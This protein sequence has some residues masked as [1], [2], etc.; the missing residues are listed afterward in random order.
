MPIVPV[1]SETQVNPQTGISLQDPF[2]AVL[3]DGGWVA[4]WSAKKD[5]SLNGSSQL[6]TDFGVYAQRFFADGSPRGSEFRV[7]TNLPGNQSVQDILATDDGGF[8]VV[9]ES[10]NQV[11][12]SSKQDVYTQK[13]DAAGTATGGEVLVNTT[14]SRTEYRPHLSSGKDGGWVVTWESND[15]V[16]S[17]AFGDEIYSQAYNASGVRVGGELRVN[18]YT[19]DF[20]YGQQAAALPGGG[21]VVVWTSFGEE[22]PAN[23]PDYRSGVYAQILDGAGNATGLPVHVNTHVLGDQEQPL[24]VVL[25][26]GGWVVAWVSFNFVHTELAQDGD[27]YGVFMQRFAANGSFVGSETQVNTYTA[28]VQNFHTLTALH[29]GG[30]VVTW[31]SY[32]QDTADSYGVYQQAYGSTGQKLGGETQVNSFT[33]DDQEDSRVVA[34][35]SGGWVVVWTSDNQ[36][37]S[38][39]GVYQQAF[40]ADGSKNGSE[41]RVNEATA[42]EQGFYGLTIE[43]LPDDKWVVL[44][45]S[46]TSDFAGDL[47]MQRVFSLNSNAA[48]TD[49]SSPALKVKEGAANSFKIGKF[50]GVDPDSST[51]TWTLLDNAGGRFKIDADDG[52][53]HVANGLLLDYEASK[54]HNINVQVSDGTSTRTETFTVKVDDVANE[55][56]TGGTNAD[57][58]GG[59]SKSDTLKGG[60]GNDTLKG[61]GGKD[62]LDGGK[63]SDTADYSDKTKAIEVTLKASG[64]TVKVDGKAEDIIKNLENVV[65]GSKNDKLTGD[66]KANSLD[67]RTG[68]DVL[69]GEGGNDTL[70]GGGGK[71]T[72]TGGAGKDHFVFTTAPG[73]KNVDTLKDFEHNKDV[74]HWDEVAFAATGPTIEDAEFRTGKAA[75]ELDDRVIYDKS[76]GK[77]YYDADGN[78]AGG[79]DQ[80]LV[81]I[82]ANKPTLDAGDFV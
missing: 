53:L 80:V 69:S 21:Q 31:R 45:S 29:G 56:L 65:G 55:N 33:H 34:L 39:R 22:N 6:V 57:S 58:L 51:L 44:W 26:D 20:Q 74:F 16:S 7:S 37:G 17:T 35:D 18:T 60:N 75:K 25:D 9:W 23:L 42:D 11:G 76:S 13:Y 64:A 46:E 70:I 50:I 4:V 62:S 79:V 36:D 52:E 3:E 77:L 72:L 15:G 63:G 81:A 24:V 68:N 41:T 67:G 66:S 12:P 5:Q 40:N 32:G 27:Q 54:S 73:T 61:G 78:L 82:L 14:T 71:D 59:G 30:W 10:T 8:V 47:L 49:I 19:T 2:L 1:S 38:G 48:P 28:S 43:V